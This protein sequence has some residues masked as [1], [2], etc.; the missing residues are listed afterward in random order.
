MQQMYPMQQQQQQQQHQHQQQQNQPPETSPGGSRPVESNSGAA[1]ARLLTMTLDPSNQGSPPLRMLAW[2]L[3]LGERRVAATVRPARLNGILSEA[4]MQRLAAIYLDKVHPCY[5]FVDRD[6]LHKSIAYAWRGPSLASA[7][8]ALLCG[9][10][11]LAYLFSGA[12]ELAVELSLVELTK[13]LL[14]PATADPPD[15]YSATAWLLRTVYLR[16]TA[17][18]EEAWLASCTTLHIIDAAGL[19][20]DLGRSNAFSAARNL[21]ALHIGQR[22]FGVAQHL[23]MWMSYDLGRCRVILQNF[24]DAPLSVQPGEYTTELL[25]LLPYSEDLDPEHG[26][27]VES[28]TAALAEVL[29]RTHSQPPSV[30]AQCNLMLCIHRR[31]HASR[32]TLT[33]EV[34][35]GVLNLIK[36]SIQAVRSSIATALPW[37]HVANIPFQVVCTLLVI[38]TAPSFALLAD[39]LGCLEAVNDAYQTAATREA[40]TAAYTLLQLHQKRREDEVKKQSEM[41]SLYPAV[42]SSSAVGSGDLLSESTLLDSWWFNEFVADLDPNTI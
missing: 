28:L 20:G 24:G 10:A 38:D 18:P 36:R 16:L 8:H 34:M 29:D 1:F 3:Y 11:A 17:K 30:L 4:E 41:L 7:Q 40:V 35:N 19:N 32:S 15:A 6:M 21:Q 39:S 31:L 37:H 23:N 12:Q 14:D 22:I 42:H 9:V 2:N 27:T 25:D 13:D 26:A 33:E 5:G